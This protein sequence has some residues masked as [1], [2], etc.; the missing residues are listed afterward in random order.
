MFSTILTEVLY[1]FIFIGI[2]FLLAKLKVLPED[3]AHVLSRVEVYFCMPA[4]TFLSFSRNFT[5]QTLSSCWQLILIGAVAT[6]LLCAV[7]HF[8]GRFLAKDSYTQYVAAYS[9]AVPNYGYVGYPLVLAMLSSEMLMKYQIFVLPLSMYIYMLAYSRLQNRPTRGLKNATN[10]AMIALFLGALFGLSGLKLPN[11]VDRVLSGASGCMA[12]LAMLLSGFTI[13][14][15]SLKEMFAKKSAYLIV[16]LRMFVI[17]LLVF[18]LTRL[19]PLSREIVL[20]LMFLYTMPCGLNPVVF[21]S[22][23]GLECRLGASTA[24]ISNIIAIGTIPLLISLVL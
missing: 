21:G 14:S 6:A 5:V 17:P 13:A 8:L 23:A 3:T 7:G 18:G 12:P 11:L 2:G 16:S 19:I 15:F 22:A 1:L 24:C 9:I 10:P 4:L 20:M